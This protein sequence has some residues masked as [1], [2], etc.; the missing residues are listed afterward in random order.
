M[1][2]RNMKVTIIDELCRFLQLESAKQLFTVD[3][4]MLV[5]AFFQ[6]ALGR[7]LTIANQPQKDKKLVSY[8]SMEI[9]PGRTLGNNLT[10]LPEWTALKAVM[11]DL[12]VDVNE[13][14]KMEMDPK[15]GSGGLGR[16]AGCL[17][18]SAATM[19]IPVMVHTIRF[20]HGLFRQKIDENGRQVP[21]KDCWLNKDGSYPFEIKRAGRAQ[22]IRFAGAEVEA[23]PYDIPV[24][25]AAH[26]E[27]AQRVNYI[28]MWKVEAIAS[29]DAIYQRIDDQLYPD[30]SNS[31]GKKLRLIQEYFLSAAAVGDMIR[32]MKENHWDIASLPEHAFLH[33][34]DTHPVLM[35][36]ELMRILRH[37]YGM[38]EDAMV[39]ICRKV[40]AYTNHTIM[41]EALEC[42]DIPLL[43]ELLPQVYS[44]ILCLH[45]RFE[46][47]IYERYD[48]DWRKLQNMDILW[49]GKARMAN[50]AIYASRRVNG[51]AKLHTDILKKRELKDL[52]E[53]F[54]GK[55]LSITNGVTQRKW[56][57][58][59]NPELAAMI[60]RRL[61]TPLWRTDF[62]M[63][64]R[65]AE[66]LDQEDVLAEFAE[67]HMKK[68]EQLSKFV[69]EYCGIDLP[70]YFIFDVQVKR[71]HEYKRQMLNC[72]R[73]IAL[74]QRLKK[75]PSARIHP[76]AFIFGGKASP[77]YLK[78]N[79]VIELIKYLETV[80]NSDSEVSQMLRVVFIEDYD[81]SKA[82]VIIPA[83]D[84]SEQ[85]ST[86]SREASG[87]G[88]MKFSM[89][90]ALIMGTLDGANVE[91]SEAV[92]KENMY[93]FGLT[94]DEVMASEA[95]PSLYNIRTALEDSSELANVIRALR[96]GTI[97]QEGECGKEAAFS[98][99]TSELLYG[100][101]GKKPDRYFLLKDFAGYMAAF[102]K[103]N[104]DYTNG[105]DWDKAGFADRAEWYKKS[106][107]NIAASGW[108]S[109]DRTICEYAEKIWGM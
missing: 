106:L 44:E 22:K 108:S 82:E 85:V 10:N 12:R 58:H 37:D 32:T 46:V 29:D 14:E 15:L 95:N 109:S 6:Y 76:T 7:I 69:H 11:D 38:D 49:N 4:S 41:A 78:A 89:N 73:I 50:L 48:G 59:A 45:R 39:E 56:L 98:G 86:A 34:N 105:V 62:D 51:V 52:H 63:I 25:G 17:V 100:E 64:S 67:A 24:L 80:V 104:W 88:N 21:E 66:L 92:G 54:P 81:V 101:D 36:P 43:E 102:H 90:G 107:A 65:L 94:S 23:V 75:N 77:A 31:E 9:L 40:F 19:D 103:M 2:D 30:D 93:I 33:I 57:A 35:I 3:H 16:L 61:E 68:K 55:F 70:P 87:T 26:G 97:C 8:V 47:E 71:M 28:R 18:E 83:A 27:S 84:V 60:D 91:I 96:D 74:Y 99:L 13:I 5:S 53:F 1:K 42:W 20:R 72:L 79:L